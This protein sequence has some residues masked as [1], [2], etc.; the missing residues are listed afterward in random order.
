MKSHIYIYNY[1]LKRGLLFPCFF[2]FSGRITIDVPIPKHPSHHQ[3][4]D[5]S[6][7]G[8]DYER[9]EG[10]LTFAQDEMTAEAAHVLCDFPGVQYPAW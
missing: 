10:E 8:R 2:V 1:Y 3:A 5:V 6:M 4:I 7:S 9:A